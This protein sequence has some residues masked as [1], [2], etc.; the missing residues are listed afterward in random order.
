[1]CVCVCMCRISSLDERGRYAKGYGENINR[2]PG[3]AVWIL[4][5]AQGEDI[6]GL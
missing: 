3:S 6:G 1:M 5:S 2:I 4:F